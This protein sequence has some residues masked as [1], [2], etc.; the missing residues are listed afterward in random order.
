MVR[1]IDDVT[2]DYWVEYGG[3]FPVYHFK[4]YTDI[5]EYGKISGHRF[6]NLVDYKNPYENDL[7]MLL[8]FIGRAPFLENKYMVVGKALELPIVKMA[9]EIYGLE[10]VEHGFSYED[11]DNGTDD[12][13]FIRDLMFDKDGERYIGEVKTFSN[14]KKIGLSKENPLPEPHISWWLQTRLECEV[15]NKKGQI[16]YYYVT[17][18]MMNAILKGRPYTLKHKYLFAS[19]PIIPT[20][21]KEPVIQD[22]FGELGIETFDGLMNYAK[23]RRDELME[24]YYQDEKGNFYYVSVPIKDHWYSKQNHVERDL[25][26]FAKQIEI[27]EIQN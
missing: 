15:L 1:K 5:V 6:V 18:T 11:L 13:H 27:N 12:F 10:N 23:D 4:V 8:Q 3:E 21:E 7:A 22:Y 19:D 25:E 9:E 24:N 20:K 14:K 17:K 26:E 16:F 2:I